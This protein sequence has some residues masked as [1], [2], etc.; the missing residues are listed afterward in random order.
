MPQQVLFPPLH[1]CNV[2]EVP[3][4]KKS[5]VQSAKLQTR[6]TFRQPNPNSG[7]SSAD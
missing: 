3:A 6:K 7:G 5:D 2:I 4:Y 1:F